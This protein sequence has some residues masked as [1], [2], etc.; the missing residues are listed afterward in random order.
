MMIDPVRVLTDTGIDAFGSYLVNLR[1]GIKQAA[2]VHLLT[3]EETSAPAPFEAKIEREPGGKSFANRF[4]F[5][6]YLAQQLKTP[7][8]SISRAHRVW[9][10]LALY[11]FD[12]ICPERPDGTR[13]VL[14]DPAYILGKDFS[15]NNY[16]RHLV[17][18]PWISV[19]MHGD[20]ARAL[21]M[22]LKVTTSPLAQRGE[23]IEQLASRQHLFSSQPVVAAAHELYYDEAS[24]RLKLGAGGSKA[25]SP[26]RLA[27]VL[28]QFDLTYDFGATDAATILQRLPREFAKWKPKIAGEQKTAA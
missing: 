10:W 27:A 13:V 18:T 28:N 17:R 15:Y 11:Y 9:A 24:D 23:L 14:A 6:T 4:A 3:A 26:R 2:P 1:A 22:P 8:V 19:V 20:Y 12:Q 21:L 25:G 16:Y 5:G 7:S